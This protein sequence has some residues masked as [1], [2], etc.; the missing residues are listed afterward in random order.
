MKKNR[1]LP[2]EIGSTISIGEF[3]HYLVSYIV[4]LLIPIVFG[5]IV[6]SHAVAIA[7]EDAIRLNRSVLAQT[8]TTVDGRV[9][10]VKNVAPALSGDPSLGRFALAADP[11]SGPIP[12][13]MLELWEQVIAFSATNRFVDTVQI[14]F[15]RSTAVVSSQFS[16]VELDR[17]YDDLFRY[18]A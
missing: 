2:K 13:Y 10:E 1:N 11:V 9:S 6:Y 12:Y 16:A 15:H 5:G 3:W 7:S 4:M 8:Q 14:H 18:D 17:I